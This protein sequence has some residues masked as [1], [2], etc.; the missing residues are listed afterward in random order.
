MKPQ[1]TYTMLLIVLLL[2]AITSLK[3]EAEENIQTVQSVCSD[4]I[5]RMSA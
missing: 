3:T 5:Y 1:K 4:A 2:I